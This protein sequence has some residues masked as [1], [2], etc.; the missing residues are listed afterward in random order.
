MTKENILKE[1]LSVFTRIEIYKY[2]KKIIN[3]MVDCGYNH[4]IVGGV[5]RDLILSVTSG[6]T[7]SSVKDIDLVV[8]AKEYDKIVKLMTDITFTS[9]SRIIKHHRFFTLSIFIEENK[10]AAIRID[11]SI[12]RKEKYPYDGALPEV[13]VGSVYDDI[14]RRDF[15]INAIALRYNI[16]NKNYDFYDPFGGIDD[17]R[18]KYIRILH[19]KSFYDDPT[20]IIRAIRFSAKLGFKIEPVTEKYLKE[21]MKDNVLL[22]ISDNR[23]VN[24]FLH[25]LKKGENLQTVVKLFKLYKVANVYREQL[26][27]L[28]S[29][30]EKKCLEIELEKVKDDYD[31]F[32]IRLLYLLENTYGKVAILGRNNATSTF[33][34]AMVSLYIPKMQRQRIY[35]AIRFIT[36]NK[37]K[38]LPPWVEK[39]ISGSYNL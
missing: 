10:D 29:T 22:K 28:F 33:K 38:N 23:L 13:S 37:K 6:K 27:G 15:T 35:E 36:S 26:G 31:R 7:S 21:A 4:Y 16:I 1:V 17:L 8:E 14:F 2:V 25:I 34:N 39:Y 20:R 12:P 18:R 3:K 19:N 11:V 30:F 24:E 32:F 5:I 9:P